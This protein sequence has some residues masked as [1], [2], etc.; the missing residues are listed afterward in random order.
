MPACSALSPAVGIAVGD[1]DEDAEG[2]EAAGTT[3][4]FEDFFGPRLGKLCCDAA[5]V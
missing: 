1:E 3:A 4:M 5:A 2:L